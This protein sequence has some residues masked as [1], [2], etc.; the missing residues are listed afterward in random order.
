[1]KTA[2]IY[3]TNNTTNKYSELQETAV[4]NA[5]FQLLSSFKDFFKIDFFI[6]NWFE[7]LGGNK[8]IDFCKKVFKIIL[9]KIFRK[10][11][12][13]I[14]H[15]KQP[16]V[17][18]SSDKS[19]LL[20]IKLMKLLLK[21]SYKTII[22]C[23]ETY[24]VLKELDSNYSSYQN[25]IVKIPHPN[26]INAYSNISV[27][28]TKEDSKLNFLYIGAINPYKN[29]DLLIDCFNEIRDENVI[30]NIAG[31]CKDKEYRS[32]LAD[33]IKNT[34]IHC[35]FRFIPDEEIVNLIQENDIV[36]LPY[37]LKSS[38]NSGT[39]ILAFSNHK[40]VVSPLIGTLKEYEDKSFFYSYEYTNEEVHKQELT[41]KI[42]KVIEDYNK[43]RKI[44]DDKG[45]SAFEAVFKE[46]SLEHITELYKNILV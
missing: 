2:Y 25:K 43:N 20:S 33:S 27:A 29:V 44:I 4:K 24:N 7:T 1:M 42:Q 28:K 37:S 39:I 19:N 36:I 23:D 13:W 45:N 15:N 34:N 5:G 26:Y 31:N 38:L 12:F 9:F 14:V 17:K 6:L 41:S 10:K 18:D 40:T 32:K 8:K 3:P 22:L 35:D 46:N 30:L 16:H 21:H 11:V